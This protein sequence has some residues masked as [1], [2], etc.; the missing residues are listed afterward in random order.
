MFWPEELKMLRTTILLLALA[1]PVAAQQ[2]AALPPAL[3]DDCAALARIAVPDVIITSAAA[4]PAGDAWSSRLRM[5]RVPLPVNRPFCRIEGTIEDSIRFELWLPAPADWNGKFLG[6]GV[7]GAAGTFNFSDLPRGVNRGYA[8]ATTD[9]GHSISDPAWMLNNP[10]AL[11]NYAIRAN[12]LLPVKAKAI[13]AAFYAKPAARSYFVGCSGGGRQGLKELQRHPDDYDGII[14]GANGPRTPEMTVRRMWEII[15][16]DAHPGLMQPADWQLIAAAGAS[17][18]DAR[19]GVQDG[20]A[21]DPRQCR[22]DIASL[23]CHAGKTTACLSAEQVAFA[24]SF[25]APLRDRAGQPIDAGI[26]PGVLI[27][28]GRSQLAL[29]TFGQA[30]R[31][32]QQWDGKDFDARRDLAAID[33]VMPELRANDPDV[34]AF[35]RRGGKLLLYTGWMDGAVAARMVI[36][37]YEALVAHAG[38]AKPAAQFAR[39][40]MLPGV[41]H[42]AGGPGAD[43]IGGSGGDAPVVD[44][45]HDLLRALEDWVEHGVVPQAMVASRVEQGVVK[46]RHLICPYPQ[47]ARYPGTGDTGDP[48]S[49]RCR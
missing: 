44:G 10:R 5:P 7:G 42:C 32:L 43:N 29:G 48:A 2:L 40:Y 3:Q 18:C 45:S 17:S 15:Q 26:L 23:Q 20:V 4:T 24:R 41:Q 34:S 19:D 21:E 38:G 36:D 14:S 12:H 30:I 1:A 35:R 8:A 49:Y 31:G 9:T 33:R 37:Y 46:R 22:F 25:Y 16:R 6:A 39:L 13:V 47:Q 27:D 28:S 11:E